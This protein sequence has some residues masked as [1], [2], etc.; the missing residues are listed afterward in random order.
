MI[1]ALGV[2]AADETTRARAAELL[3]EVLR[4]GD[5]DADVA[6]VVVSLCARSGNAELWDEL[7]RLRTEVVNP[8]MVLR[9][10]HA[11][12]SFEDPV[13]RDRTLALF[14]TDAVRTQD[15][16]FA[17]IRMCTDRVSGPVTW[18]FLRDHWGELIAKFPDTSVSRLVEGLVWR[19]EPGL[20]EDIEAFFATHPVPQGHK[21]VEQN[22][23]RLRVS[24]TLR[25][26]EGA[27]LAATLRS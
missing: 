2:L 9:Y 18:A 10:L 16:P 23:E 12:G 15:I 21:Q 7:N 11:L 19:S 20:G 26:R 6:P 1:S 14:L 4:G 24:R 13:L 3:P 22:L 8:Q 17:L 25:D 27:P 5:I